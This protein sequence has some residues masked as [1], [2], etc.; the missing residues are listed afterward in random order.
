MESVRYRLIE[1]IAAAARREEGVLALWE[2]G[3][4]AFGRVDEYSDIDLCV[5]VAAGQVEVIAD[6]IR[7]A[8]SS[9]A[10][11]SNECRKQTD[12]GST[13]FFW[14]FEGLPAYNFVDIDFAEYNDC[15]VKIDPSVEGEPIIHLDR[16]GYLNV[17]AESPDERQLR[18]G[19]RIS[20][21]ARVFEISSVLVERHILRGHALH[22]YGEYQRSMIR[23][24]IELLRIKHCPQ[25]SSWHTT[26]IAWDLP[27]EVNERLRSLVMV[28]SL[29]QMDR[30]LAVV[31]SWV[32]SL[33]QDLDGS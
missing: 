1:S 12:S 20:E 19:P 5:L 30:N 32:V 13:Q 29:E 8:L 23:P 22:A 26:Y 6:A 21:I 7:T 18:V 14:Q 11:I 15:A 27:A 16:C 3:S 24:L 33:L 4:A 10:R 31:Q 25:R 2:C 17:V 28:S 9:I